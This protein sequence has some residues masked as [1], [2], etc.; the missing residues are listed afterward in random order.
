MSNFP[1]FHKQR[2]DPRWITLSEAVKKRAGGCCE[3]CGSR[4]RLEGHHGY[5]R[6]NAWMW[7]Y[8]PDTLWCLCNRCHHAVEGGIK[9]LLYRN[10]GRLHPDQW[11]PI[12][13]YILSFPRPQRPDLQ[14]GISVR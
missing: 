3:M 8:E 14:L 1:P 7:E 6:N 13:F 10:L 5:Y 12:Y 4:S 2:E 11:W 9:L